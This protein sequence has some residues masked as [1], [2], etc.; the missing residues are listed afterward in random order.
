[1]KVYGVPGYN[2]QYIG[3]APSGAVLV[4]EQRPTMNH[5]CVD[6]SD[7]TGSW[8]FD[9]YRKWA[10]DMAASDADMPRWAEDLWE[11]V[12]VSK[13]PTYVQEQYNYKKTLRSTKPIK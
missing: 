11:A 3:K 7:G 1:M 6:N 10:E 4:S 2:I 12:G 8:T 13:A 5:I 9:E